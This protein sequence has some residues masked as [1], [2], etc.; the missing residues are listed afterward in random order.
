MDK[1]Y[2]DALELHQ[3]FSGKLE[4]A[5]KVPL[6][7]RDDL[8]LAYTPGVGQVSV[9]IGEDKK[10]ARLYTLKRN[11]IAVITDGSAILGLGNL[12]PE[13]AIPVMEGK[14]I[15]FK[16]FAGLD[17]FPI[18]L[19]TQD[20]EEIIQAVK[21]IAPVFG[22]INLEDIS[23]PRCFEIEKRLIAELDIPV[24]H[25]D[26][27]GTAT[28][29]LAALIN[30]L[31]VVHKEAGAV[32]VVILGAGAAGIA[33]AKLLLKYRFKN[34]ILCDRQGALYDGRANLNEAKAAIAALT[35][36]ENKSGTL[37]DV[38]LEA[39]VLIGVSGPNLVT[40]EMV[41]SMSPLAIIIAMSNPVPEIMP[42]IAKEA[43][44]AVVATGR[45]DFPNQ[46]NNALVFPGVFR[47]ALDNNVQRITDEMLIEAAKNLAALVAEPSADKILP[48]IFEETVAPVVAAAIKD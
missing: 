33:T 44:A 40:K 10:L 6:A 24:M 41:Q 15:L 30:S 14:A 32:K 36:H 47:G 37:A 18:C 22:G 38:L 43:G 21:L 8:S 45:S 20:V 13:A 29:A 16:R 27:R 17:A 35:N 23:A 39:D 4:V 31:K 34:I 12:G 26:Q 48:S 2:S 11:T 9:A 3:K 42:D 46:C 5:S 7:T 28:V 1:V 19:A 25:D